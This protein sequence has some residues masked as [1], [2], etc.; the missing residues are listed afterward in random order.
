MKTFKFYSL[1]VSNSSLSN[2]R[3]HYVDNI[4]VVKNMLYSSLDKVISEN[5]HVSV[6]V[7]FGD[8]P[9]YYDIYRHEFDILSESDIKVDLL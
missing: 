6:H 8:K 2:S 3:V 1:E 5:D 4:D 7:N 9:F